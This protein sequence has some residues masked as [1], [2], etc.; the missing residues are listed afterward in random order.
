MPT[1]LYESLS[2]LSYNSILLCL[3]FYKYYFPFYV[4]PSLLILS[5]WDIQ[6]YIDY[7]QC[8]ALSRNLPGQYLANIDADGNR[9]TASMC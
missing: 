1:I 4:S 9:L 2:V 8:I 5:K 7:I 3:N 6:P